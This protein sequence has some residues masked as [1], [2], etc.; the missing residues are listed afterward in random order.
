VFVITPDRNGR[1]NVALT[2]GPDIRFIL[3]LTTNCNAPDQACTG[4]ALAAQNGQQVQ[5]GA[6]VVAGTPYYLVV[7]H[8]G[9]PGGA[10]FLDVTLQ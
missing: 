10:F 7:D 2:P 9:M 4:G 6:N 3:T 8:L 1:L 5:V